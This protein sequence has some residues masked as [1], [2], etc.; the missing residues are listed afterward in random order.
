[1][2]SKRALSAVLIALSIGTAAV[3]PVALAGP[4]SARIR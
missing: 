1:M 4:A 3:A 2:K